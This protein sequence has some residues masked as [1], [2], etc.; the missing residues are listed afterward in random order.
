[1]WRG[2]ALVDSGHM[3]WRDASLE[4]Y[5]RELSRLLSEFCRSCWRVTLSQTEEKTLPSLFQRG[6]S[7]S[8]FSDDDEDD[9][10]AGDGD[11]DSDGH[12]TMV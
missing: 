8:S 9:A 3:L 12:V 7:S 11:G 5:A 6:E 4:F 2:D 1:M 10:E